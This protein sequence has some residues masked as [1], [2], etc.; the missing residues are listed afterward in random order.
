MQENKES[1]RFG[2]VAKYDKKPKRRLYE[3]LKAQGSQ[4]NQNITF[5]SDGG[6]DVRDLQLYMSPQAE[7][8]LDWFH[9]TMR[10]QD[11]KQIATGLKITEKPTIKDRLKTLCCTN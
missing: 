6:E 8:I 5:I 3:M 11:M 10:I 2:F 4:M 1:K 9:I 7:H